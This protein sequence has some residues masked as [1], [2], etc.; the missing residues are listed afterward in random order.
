VHVVDKVG[1]RSQWS[2][3]QPLVTVPDAPWRAEPIWC[4]KTVPVAA[5]DNGEL[6]EWMLARCEFELSREVEG[7]AES[8]GPFT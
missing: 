1:A 2:D 3:R 6:A 7:M 5:A 4:Y 8:N